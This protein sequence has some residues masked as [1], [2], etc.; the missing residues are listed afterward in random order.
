MPD[1]RTWE[2]STDAA[3]DRQTGPLVP[4]ILFTIYYCLG[5]ENGKVSLYQGDKFLNFQK[6]VSQT[7]PFTPK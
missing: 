2:R 4:R 5:S 3:W 6:L 7:F 1:G